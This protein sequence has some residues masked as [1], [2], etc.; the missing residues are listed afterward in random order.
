MKK[1][2]VV[3]GAAGFLGLHFTQALLDGGYM[4]YGIDLLNSTQI[5]N[6]NYF[7]KNGDIT[8]EKTLQEIFSEIARNHS[9]LDLLVNNAAI[10]HKIDS[11]SLSSKKNNRFEDFD[12]ELIIPEFRVGILGSLLCSKY[13]LKIMIPQRA[14]SIINIASDLSIISPNQNIYRS[15]D[16]FVQDFFKPVS[17]SIIKHGLVGLTKYLATYCAP[18]NIRCNSVSPGPVL[19]NQP[20][21]FLER[22]RELIPLGRLANPDEITKAVIFLASSDSSYLTGHNLVVDGGRTIW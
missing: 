2:A 14:G 18:Y 13:A 16:N 8:D 3:T 21:E 7:H 5:K 10:D 6:Q 17:Y 4:V 11:S 12:H 19:N 20:E 22:L 1:V 15:K 9:K